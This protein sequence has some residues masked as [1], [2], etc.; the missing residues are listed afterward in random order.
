MGNIEK[1][2]LIFTLYIFISFLFYKW[3]AK[4]YLGIIYKYMDIMEIITVSNQQRATFCAPICQKNE[5]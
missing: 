2:Q 3:C 5:N 1:P 4:K